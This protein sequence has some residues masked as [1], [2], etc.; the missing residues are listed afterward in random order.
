MADYNV[1]VVGAGH[2]GLAA[3]TVLAKEGLK[4][5]SVEKQRYVGGMAGTTEYFKG[6]KHNIGA[7]ALM[8]HRK[9]L[10]DAFGMN[11]YGLEVIDPP[12]SFHTIGDPPDAPYILYNDQNKLMEHLQRDHGEAGVQALAKLFEL[13]QV[14]AEPMDKMRYGPPKSAGSLIDE[15]PDARTKD[16]M[17]RWIYGSAMDIIREL[18][19]DRSKSRVIQGSLAAMAIDGINLGPYSPGSAFSMA[20]HFAVPGVGNWYQFPKGG[21]G[22]FSEALRRSLEERG[23]EVK[24]GTRVKRILVSKGMAEGVELAKGEKITAKVVL[25]NADAY[26]TFI[27]MVGEE[28]VPSDYVQMVKRINFQNP[29]IQIHAT[30]KELPEFTGALAY[31]NEGPLRAMMS[32]IPSPEHLERCYES[33]K[34]G[35]LP[36]TPASYYAIPSYFDQSLAPKGYHTCTFFANLYPVNAPKNQQEKLKEEMADKIIDFWTQQAP[37]FKDAIMDRA[38]FTALTFEGMF[39][40][41]GGCYC[42]GLHLVEQMFDLRPF[43]GWSPGYKTPIKNLYLCGCGCHPGGGV[44]GIPGYKCANEV[45]KNWKSKK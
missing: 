2:N 34:W 23:G 9:E 28:H 22:M 16:I 18:F 30:L 41:T 29:W 33:F 10:M 31:A 39:G 6:F 3:A 40:I 45:L 37:N 21:M 36:E 25:S 42:H 15:A 44:N 43:P 14:I 8:A 17:R 12:I 38:V 26:A 24:L 1:I 7:W 20:Y 11:R 35:R 27:G 5:L 13:C 19:P 32:Y 4:V